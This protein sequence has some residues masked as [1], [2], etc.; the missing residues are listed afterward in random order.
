[1]SERMVNPKLI[2]DTAERIS[3]LVG[4]R[5]AIGIEESKIRLTRG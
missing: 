1:M 2:R 3:W 5:D 4:Y